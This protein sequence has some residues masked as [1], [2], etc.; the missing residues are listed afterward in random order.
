MIKFNEVKKTYPGDIIALDGVSFE[1]DR[2][3]FSF[4]V[5]PSGA[6]KSTLIRLLVR[7][8]LP[9]NGEIIFED[10]NVP[11]IPNKLLPI[12]RQQLGIVFQDLKLI[13]SKTVE[14]NIQFA[15]EISGKHADEVEQTTQYLLNAANLKG[16]SHLFPAELSGGEKQK[17]AIARAL[18]N[19]PKVF[20][21]DEPTG[22]L[23]KTTAFEILDILKTIN[24]WGT[25]VI[26]ITHDSNL[27]DSMK[28]RK[29]E[30][31]K[32]KIMKDS[33][34]K[35]K[36]DEKKNFPGLDT[37]I[38]KILSEKDIHDEEKLL[39]KTEEQLKKYGLSEKQSEKLEEYL[40]NYLSNKK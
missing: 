32:G 26:V 34:P 23:D 20:I 25:T 30:M 21:A 40:Q 36:S 16:R 2:G 29:I 35:K 5:G 28:A 7:Q 11:K 22:N 12:F 19:D 14:E 13:P 39:S 10:V 38:I 9:T 18:A 8:E 6:G 24:A 1:I 31:N 17:V 15:L 33:K 4:I 27:V 3:E 37:D